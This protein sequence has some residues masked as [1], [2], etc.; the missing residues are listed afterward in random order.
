MVWSPQCGLQDVVFVVWSL[1]CSFHDVVSMVFSSWVNLA[2]SSSSHAPHVNSGPLAFS[3]MKSLCWLLLFWY[4][5]GNIVFISPSSGFFLIFGS[6]PSHTSLPTWHLTY[7]LA[8]LIFMSWLSSHTLENKLILCHQNIYHK[9]VLSCAFLIH[10]MSLTFMW[11]VRSRVNFI[12]SDMIQVCAWQ[13]EEIMAWGYLVPV[14]V[15]SN[16]EPKS[17]GLQKKKKS[18]WDL[19][20][21]IR[22]PCFIISFLVG[23]C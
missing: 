11:P 2:L 9:C 22:N 23:W 10:R 3:S 5:H 18:S 12:C 20:V 16:A 8:E 19:P 15:N 7:V 6:I 21:Q 1:W 17:S 4:Y 14:H 13:E